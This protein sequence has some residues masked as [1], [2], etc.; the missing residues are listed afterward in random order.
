MINFFHIIHAVTFVSDAS[1]NDEF[2]LLSA[3]PPFSEAFGAEK[4]FTD[5]GCDEFDVRASICM[6]FVRNEVPLFLVLHGDGQL[7]AAGGHA[8]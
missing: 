8:G 4:V 7:L 3:D 1:C 2:T 6:M 5:D